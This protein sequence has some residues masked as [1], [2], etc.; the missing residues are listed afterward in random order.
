MINVDTVYQTVQALANKE[1]RG[2]LTPQEFN[3]FATNAQKDIFESY[4][5]DLDAIRKAEPSNRELGDSLSHVL[6][7]IQNTDN[8]AIGKVNPTYSA[9]NGMTIPTTYI[10]G[11]ITYG[12]ANGKRS[13]TKIQNI[14]EI[15]DLR[16]SKWHKQAFDDIVYFEDGYNNIR[17]WTGTG[18]VTDPTRLEIE[19]ISGFVGLVYWGYTVV[20]EKALYNPDS[21]KN[22]DLHRSEQPDLVAKILK[23][24]GISTEDQLLYQAGAAEEVLN[25]QQQNK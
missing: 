8:V 2:Y 1:Q 9:A 24:A 18:E 17:V 19:Y 15:Y 13:L 22:F 14:D 6:F 16:G 23:L 11:K 7:K 21:Y 3:L 5:Y 25:T 10:T 12:D 20:N 4:I